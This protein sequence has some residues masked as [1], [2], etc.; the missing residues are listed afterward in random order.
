MF[1]PFLSGKALGRISLVSLSI[2]CSFHFCGCKGNDGFHIVN[3]KVVPYKII[4][5]YKSRREEFQGRRKGRWVAEGISGV[6]I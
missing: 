3:G 1:I 5:S 6:Q 4:K 2:L